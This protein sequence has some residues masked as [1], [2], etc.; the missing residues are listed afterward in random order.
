MQGDELGVMA[1]D[2][3][4]FQSMEKKKYVDPSKYIYDRGTELGDYA[5]VLNP[6]Y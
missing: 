1:E 3:I 5:N 6:K 2:T 4:Y